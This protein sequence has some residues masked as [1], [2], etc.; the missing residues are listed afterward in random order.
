MEDIT[1][2]RKKL[3]YK[4][5]NRG[6]KETDLLLGEFT[7]QHINDFSLQELIMLD[8][9]LDEPDGDIFNWITKKISIPEKHDNEVMALLQNFRIFNC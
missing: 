8:A 2:Y 4:S 9:I 6:W 3:F 7:K 5:A 1:I